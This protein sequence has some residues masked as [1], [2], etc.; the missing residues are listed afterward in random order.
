M[1]IVKLLELPEIDQVLCNIIF[2][3]R[4]KQIIICKQWYITVLNIDMPTLS[5]YIKFG[6]EKIRCWKNS[7]FKKKQL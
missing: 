1:K 6:E 4:E 7:L 5:Y 2:Q 3:W